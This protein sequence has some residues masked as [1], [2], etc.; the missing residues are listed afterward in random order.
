MKKILKPKK[1][2]TFIISGFEVLFSEYGM[3]SSHAQFMFFFSSYMVL[4]VAIR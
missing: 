3:P 2:C 4:F 1:T